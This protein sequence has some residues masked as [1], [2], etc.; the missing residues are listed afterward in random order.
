MNNFEGVSTGKWRVHTA[1][2]GL[3]EVECPV[4]GYCLPVAAN[5]DIVSLK[6]KICGLEDHCPSCNENMFKEEP[7]L[8]TK[9]ASFAVGQAEPSSKSMVINCE[10]ISLE[11]RSLGIVVDISESIDNIDTVEING[12]KFVREVQV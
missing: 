6:T 7:K 2:N 3:Y 5:F 11:Q 8:F 4:C 12:V 1:A 10:K 9:E